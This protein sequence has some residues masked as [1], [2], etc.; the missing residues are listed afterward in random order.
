[1]SVDITGDIAE[2]L[3]LYFMEKQNSK[4]CI[5]DNKL[6]YESIYESLSKKPKEELLTILNNRKN[7]NIPCCNCYDTLYE[8][9]EK[10][11]EIILCPESGVSFIINT[12][13]TDIS[14]DDIVFWSGCTYISLL[15]SDSFYVIPDV[16][17]ST[18]WF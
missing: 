6:E 8:N 4:C 10:V 1:M 16:S 18:W 17:D 5:C 2:F 13:S 11:C 12:S 9:K 7:L 15:D 3:A 14:P